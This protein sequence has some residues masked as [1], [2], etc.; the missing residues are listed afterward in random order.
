M[1]IN[2]VETLNV[3]DP[4]LITE[5][6]NRSRTSSLQ[7]TRT[8][9]LRFTTAAKMS[10]LAGEDG[11][12]VFGSRF[13]GYKGYEFFTL[14][15]HGYEKT[16]YNVD[17]LYGTKGN[18]GL[19]VG[20][21]YKQNE[22]KLVYTHGTDSPRNFPPPG[23]TGAKVERVRSGNVLRMTIEVSCY[24]QDQLQLLDTICFV[25][26]MTCI[27]EWGNTIQRPGPGGRGIG[28]L[29]TIE[30]K[31]NF[32]D[33]TKAR[34]YIRLAMNKTSRTDF[35]KE[36]CE[37]NNFNYDWA[38]A[39]IANVKTIIQNNIYKTTITAYGKADNLMYISAYATAN[40]LSPSLVAQEQTIAT[41]I[42]EYF[43][44]NGKFSAALRGFIENPSS[45]PDPYKDKII[46]F[47]NP[48]NAEEK[49][50]AM[51]AAQA[52]G[53]ANDVGYED[54]YFISMDFLI[55]ILN[56]NQ[57][58]VLS[59]LNSAIS[60]GNVL[61]QLLVP[62]DGPDKIYVGFN[63]YLRSTSPEVCIIFNK[64][65]RDNI[66]T[67][68]L[69]Q[70]TIEQIGTEET[71]AIG[72]LRTSTEATDTGQVEQVSTAIGQLNKYPFGNEVNTVSGVTTLN[73]GVWINSKQVQQCFLN[74][75]TIFEGLETL[76]RNINAATENYWD[77]GLFY[78]EEKL[79]FRILDNNVRLLTG[80]TQNTEIY[81]FNK[82]LQSDELNA[83]GP[84][85][86]D[87][88][89]ATDY[90]KILFSQLAVS[91]INGGRLLSDVNRTG[92]DFKLAT[93]VKDIFFDDPIA[94]RREAPPIV[95]NTRIETESLG[96]LIVG[97]RTT[98]LGRI[99][100]TE[101]YTPDSGGADTKVSKPAADIIRQLYDIR[102]PLTPAQSLDFQSRILRLK[103]DG[104]I[105]G[106]DIET[107]KTFIAGRLRLLVYNKKKQERDWYITAAKDWAA[108][109]N[110]IDEKWIGN[111]Q[112]D[113]VEKIDKSREDLLSEL[114]TTT[115]LSTY[116]PADE[117]RVAVD[118]G[119][120]TANV[121]TT[122]IIFGGAGA[123][124]FD[125]RAAAPE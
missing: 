59:I 113:V 60:T 1:A 18:N 42:T 120:G 78:D 31:L 55:Y 114:F 74:A 121:A 34:A 122:P 75:R 79:A 9:F 88:Q 23:I 7:A 66:Q 11:N 124:V 2:P 54:A 30:K 33:L 70:T 91:G 85:V 76:L 96:N 106:D 87:I 5:L 4:K 99:L 105:T 20:T 89:I 103:Q 111:P 123:A 50:N 32:K 110:K 38:V 112:V 10:D 16:D 100:V 73:N 65:A 90:P 92:V 48:I 13:N 108:K 102:E 6:R 45:I 37:P 21:T 101:S 95:R 117:R 40:P 17:D 116:I 104:D 81:E 41:S 68:G 22:Q 82:K 46:K 58:G 98:A 29:E 93:S 107:L 52:T 3:F 8:P 94:P 83:Q 64:K 62:L 67:G 19:V 109:G 35:I 27:L 25:P 44:L 71:R 47:S 118:T 72:A 51:G 14:G 28:G 86:L 115:G 84:E 97:L 26:G 61:Q 69:K 43:K 15:L 56:N 24:T 36:W 53:T 119:D 80:L 12:G 63:E 125:S 77:L 57:N 49:A 39:H